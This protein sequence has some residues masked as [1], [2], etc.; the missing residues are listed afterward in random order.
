MQSPKEEAA[1]RAATALALST[2]VA[3]HASAHDYAREFDQRF[4]AWSEAC[5]LAH[6]QL[7]ARHGEQETR[8]SASFV[9]AE[10]EAALGCQEAVQ[11][12][13]QQAA[14]L[15]ARQYEASF[16]ALTRV[17]RAE[18]RAARAH[19]V[20]QEEPNEHQLA[21]L[22]R[23]QRVER[24]E[25][26]ALCE[27]TEQELL[28]TRARRLFQL[29]GAPPEQPQPGPEPAVPPPA[30]QY[31][32]IPHQF[33]HP[34]V[35]VHWP[36]YA[37]GAAQECLPPQYYAEQYHAEQQ[38]AEQYYADA[39]QY[40]AEQHYAEQ[41]LGWPAPVHWPLAP[42]PAGWG[43][44]APAAQPH[45]V[46][47][48]G[49]DV[50]AV[51]KLLATL[52]GG[53]QSQQFAAHTREAVAPHA[54]ASNSAHP[55][56]SP[57]PPPPPPPPSSPPQVQQRVPPTSLY[58]AAPAPPRPARL[59]AQPPPQPSAQPPPDECELS[60]DSSDASGASETSSLDSAF[61][62]AATQSARLLH[63]SPCITLTMHT[64]A[65]EAPT[66]GRL[67]L[68][69]LATAPNGVAAVAAVPLAL[70]APD[71]GDAKPQSSL[72]A[73]IAARRASETVSACAFPTL[74]S[75][76]TRPSPARPRCRG[77]PAGVH[78]HRFPAAVLLL[79]ARQV[80]AGKG[81][82]AWRVPR[83][84][85]R[86]VW[87]HAPHHR[88]PEWPRATGQGAA[89]ARCSRGRCQPQR[90]HGPPL[91]RLLWL[92]A[93]RRLPHL[94]GGGRLCAQRGGADA[95]RG[96]Q[97]ELYVDLVRQFSFSSSSTTTD[98]SQKTGRT[99]VVSLQSSR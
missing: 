92:C 21:D 95:L 32:R 11:L 3:A 19:R 85:A 93:A 76:L 38:Y 41:P 53:L 39:E 16:E 62:P 80:P 26:Q 64:G 48:G 36:E 71:A 23:A 65:E 61:A 17:E 24:E 57:P 60:D 51:A 82:A 15:A 10:R 74:S 33:E 70:P 66:A 81:A 77:H 84:R 34:G 89:A 43:R 6:S 4:A 98:S 49:G 91:C 42:I 5:V 97:V 7:R 13:Q 27:E 28:F 47:G 83:G 54:P 20:A 8:L 67:A 88:L 96:H 30:Y 86:S 9:M 79:P 31:E 12:R 14:H 22:R 63:V 2:D 40:Y 94:T 44:T 68:A 69:V 52:L 87:Q 56:P 25:L 73:L 59:D 50:D 29:G 55:E 18:Q 1:I 37:M 45:V 90:Q 35:A 99:Y 58:I 46:T 75:A 78:N 72:G